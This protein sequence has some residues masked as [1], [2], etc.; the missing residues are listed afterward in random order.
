MVANWRYLLS[1]GSYG[2][3]EQHRQVM[4]TPL[5]SEELPWFMPHPVWWCLKAVPWVNLVAKH[6]WCVQE[7][8]GIKPGISSSSGEF[9]NA[10]LL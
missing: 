4:A 9:G 3:D 6:S 7:H 2:A 10:L 8:T 1:L 5:N